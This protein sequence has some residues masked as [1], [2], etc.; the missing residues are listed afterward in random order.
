MI[1]PQFR[2]RQAFEHGLDEGERGDL[3]QA[4]ARGNDFMTEVFE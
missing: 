3:D 2:V 1:S 4:H